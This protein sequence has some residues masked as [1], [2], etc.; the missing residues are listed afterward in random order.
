MPPPSARRGRLDRLARRLLRQCR[1]RE[2]PRHAKEG[3]HQPPILADQSRG[4]H[5]DVRVHRDVLQPTTTS[6]RL[7][8]LSPAEA[9]VAAAG[10]VVSERERTVHRSPACSSMVGGLEALT[11]PGDTLVDTDAV[12]LETSL[13]ALVPGSSAR[14]SRGCARA[15]GRSTTSTAAT[16]ARSTTRSPSWTSRSCARTARCA[17]ATAT[18]RRP[19][20]TRY[21]RAGGPLIA[22]VRARSGEPQPRRKSRAPRRRTRAPARRRR[23]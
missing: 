20:P 9:V 14:S 16:C 6:P 17:A 23:R 10:P 22:R 8:M 4:A 21:T 13:F 3:P 1:D 19:R 11:G 2:L 15:A 5:G 18:P 12:I 7:A